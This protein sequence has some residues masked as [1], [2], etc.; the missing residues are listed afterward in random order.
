M[1]HVF[2]G[3]LFTHV[4]CCCCFL[5]CLLPCCLHVFYFSLYKFITCVYIRLTHTATHTCLTSVVM[6]GVLRVVPLLHV[7]VGPVHLVV[8]N[9][10]NMFTCLPLLLHFHVVLHV[11]LACLTCLTFPDMAGSGFVL[12]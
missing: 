6:F 12:K 5:L 1:V 3:L 10:V 9:C 8:Y 11:A 4:V 7:G 2:T